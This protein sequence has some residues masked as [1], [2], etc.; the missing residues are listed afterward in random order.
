MDI[1]TL[2]DPPFPPAS[3]P[4]PKMPRL[5]I[6]NIE[7]AATILADAGCS[8]IGVAKRLID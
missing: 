4:H 1:E 3:S 2:D 5:R 7:M 8:Q 6:K